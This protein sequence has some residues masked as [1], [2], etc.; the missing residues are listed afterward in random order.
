MSIS[1]P[2]F[3]NTPYLNPTVW[4]Y[5]LNKGMFVIIFSIAFFSS[6]LT[7]GTEITDDQHYR[8]ISKYTGKALDISNDDYDW[9]EKH[10]IN[11]STF[12]TQQYWKIHKVDQFYQIVNVWGKALDSWGKK[13]EWVGKY[14]P[15]PSS[16][17]HY[18]H[19]L[20]KIEKV[21]DDYYQIISKYTGKALDCL[22]KNDTKVGKYNVHSSDHE[23]YDHQL[24]KFVFLDSRK[25]DDGM[26]ADTYYKHPD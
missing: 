25:V 6:T 2:N 9:V 5:F 12:C 17:E 18:N 22:G 23:H 3:Q 4:V 16:H 20:W 7:F 26:L 8:I 14:N 24:W 15:H 19:Q 10:P 21:N 1:K 13:V 11:D